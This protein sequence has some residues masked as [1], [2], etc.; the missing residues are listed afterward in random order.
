MDDHPGQSGAAAALQARMAALEASGADRCDPV[1]FRYI[2][3][4]ASRSLAQTGAVAALV[5]DNAASALAAYESELARARCAAALR[6]EEV[7]TRHPEAAEQARALYD[8]CEFSRLRRLAAGYQR[9]PATPAL[10]PLLHL[11]DARQQAAADDLHS[12]S[13][14]ELPRSEAAGAVGSPLATTAGG[15]P[16]TA[17][18]LKAARYF[19][20]ALQL[21]RADT[22]VSRITA[23]APADSG[24]LNSQKLAIRSLAAMRDLSPAYLGRFVSYVDTLF[25]LES[26]GEK[27]KP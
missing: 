6:V 9:P 14:G 17:S 26:V 2:K 11:L 13:S 3:A 23:E 20:E 19:R 8:A 15:P 12:G 4:L 27:N 18:E 22:L 16:A 10:A 21:Q 5:A 24:P 7:A 25:W 1:R